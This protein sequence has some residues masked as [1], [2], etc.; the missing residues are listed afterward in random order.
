MQ[1]RAAPTQPRTERQGT[2]NASVPAAPLDSDSFEPRDGVKGDIARMLFYM[3]VRYAGADGVPDL[4]LIDEDSRSGPLLGHLCTLL[5]WHEA[6]PVDDLEHRRHE[7]IVDTQGNRNP[8]IDRPEFAAAIW[9]T[10]CG[11]N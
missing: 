11:V 6:D 1:Q 3:D 7:R 9:D 5:A 2:Y 4:E 8:F 10:A